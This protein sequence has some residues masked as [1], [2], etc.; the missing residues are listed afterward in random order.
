MLRRLD[1]S[2]CVEGAAGC[3]HREGKVSSTRR[4]L[5]SWIGTLPQPRMSAMEATIF[6]GWIYD[7][8]LPHADKVNAI[9]SGSV[10]W[11]VQPRILP[12]E[13]SVVV[14]A[15]EPDVCAAAVIN[16]D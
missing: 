6:T 14:V 2:Y 1:I 5:D 9:W 15:A 8:L 7:H 11:P 16:L 3:V 13:R 10:L 12:C 4:E